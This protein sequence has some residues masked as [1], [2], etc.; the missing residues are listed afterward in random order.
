MRRCS[1][2]RRR[3]DG[4][5]L[6]CCVGH[7]SVSYGRGPWEYKQFGNSLRIGARVLDFDTHGVDD[8]STDFDDRIIECFG[9]K[10]GVDEDWGCRRAMLESMGRGLCVSR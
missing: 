9:N 8:K 5:G 10:Y 6:Y 7:E 4:S 2:R 3:C 1:K